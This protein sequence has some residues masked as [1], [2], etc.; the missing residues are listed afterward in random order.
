MSTRKMLVV[1]LTRTNAVLGVATR[2]TVGAP[3]A[4]DLVGSALLV[5][6]T[7]EESSVAVPVDELTVKEVDYSDD[8][9]RQPL[10]HVVDPTGTVIATS[11]AVSNI[12]TPGLTIKVKV[13]PVPPADR[14][15]LVVVDGGGSHEP[16]KFIAKTIV[17]QA[18][19]EV[20]I[21]GVP[22]GDHMVLASV[23]GYTPKLEVK[24]FS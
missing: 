19:T 10:A 13:S 12:G 14:T 11:S 3:A 2:R 4:D 23:D 8:V 7:N 16:L 15:V 18:E 24:H 20:A 1:L 6:I 5:R 9:F 17:N 21:S 22:P